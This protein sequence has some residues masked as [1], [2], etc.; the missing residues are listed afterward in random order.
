MFGTKNHLL[1]IKA[2]ITFELLLSLVLT[3]LIVNLSFAQEDEP[4][5]V[6][7]GELEPGTCNQVNPIEINLALCEMEKEVPLNVCNLAGREI[8]AATFIEITYDAD[9]AWVKEGATRLGDDVPDGWV[10]YENT[11]EV[12]NG[13]YSVV[14]V[15]FGNEP[16]TEDGI[17]LYLTFETDKTDPTLT[18]PLTITSVMLED[19]EPGVPSTQ[20]PVEIVEN[21]IS[22]VADPAQA[23]NEL[24]DLVEAMN[25]HHGTKESLLTKLYAAQ[26]SLDRGKSDTA[27]NQLNAFINHVEAQRGKKL[28]DAQA[29]ELVERANCIINA[30][31]G[32]NKK[33]PA[34]SKGRISPA[35]K[36]TVTLGKLKSSR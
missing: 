16:M 17:I 22:L 14:I 15:A 9:V 10:V 31:G 26:D 1:T 30:C 21:T 13:F 36:L 28:T 11:T 35:G 24:I 3:S 7:I 25:I 6:S 19:V 32:K 20:H 18:S 33:A 4:I 2:T 5:V 8:D 23:L 12:K 27:A 29:D 34:L